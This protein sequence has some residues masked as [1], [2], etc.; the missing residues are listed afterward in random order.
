MK[1]SHVWPSLRCLLCTELAGW[2]YYICYNTIHYL[3]KKVVCTDKVSPCT[4][5]SLTQTFQ[6]VQDMCMHLWHILMQIKI[7]IYNRLAQ[8][9]NT[10]TCACM[11]HLDPN[12]N[13][14]TCQARPST[15]TK[16]V[17]ACMEQ[18]PACSK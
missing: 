18:L 16:H 1:A 10:N 5:L 14:Y 6:K 13:K 3:F 2:I 12:K 15:S 11:A 9:K 4:H 8:A 17:Y 7:N